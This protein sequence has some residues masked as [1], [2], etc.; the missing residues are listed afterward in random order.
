MGGE[1]TLTLAATPGSQSKLWQH[2]STLAANTETGAQR[3]C[4]IS[5]P[6]DARIQTAPAL[7][8]LA[9]F[10]AGDWTG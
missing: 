6:G 7:V 4:A 2:S 8:K 9:P 1:A 5:I 3:G 10:G